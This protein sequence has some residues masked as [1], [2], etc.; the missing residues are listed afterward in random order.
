MGRELSL[1][2]VEY[3]ME[4]YLSGN[5]KVKRLL[6]S[7][8][9]HILHSLNPD[10]FEMAVQECEG[11]DGRFNANGVDL[12]RNFPHYFD[13]LNN[14]TLEEAFIGREPETK[15]SFS[16][17]KYRLPQSTNMLKGTYCSSSK[18][19]DIF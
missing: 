17:N 19:F 14:M 2:L 4:K 16:F 1:A 15:V 7:I 12:N 10:G 9:L 6:D 11:V 18:S 8:D 13:L 5:R 3:L